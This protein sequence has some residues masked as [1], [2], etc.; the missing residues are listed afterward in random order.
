M[1]RLRDPKAIGLRRVMV[2]ERT[3]SLADDFVVVTGLL[4]PRIPSEPL[5]WPRIPSEPLRASVVIDTRRFRGRGIMN[6]KRI[7]SAIDKLVLGM[8]SVINEMPPEAR[9]RALKSI[10]AISSD[11]ADRIEAPS[12]RSH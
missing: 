5:L 12:S 1:L 4:W 3:K 8:R 7:L 6:D 11:I 2:A 10:R 9:E